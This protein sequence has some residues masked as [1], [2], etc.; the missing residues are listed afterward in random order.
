MGQLESG[1][2]KR[3]RRNQVKKIVLETI[4][5]AG[6]ISVAI[7]AP[8]V[9]G[10]MAKLGMITHPRQKEL[11]GR[12]IDR[13]YAQG[14]LKHCRGGLHL[15]QKGETHLRGLQFKSFSLNKPF[16]WDGKWR[17]LIF[18]ISER[19]RKLRD[20]VRR[21]LQ[22]NGFVRI[23]D[24]VWVYPYD[25]EDWVNLWKADRRIGKQLLYLIVDSIESDSVL[26]RKF[27]I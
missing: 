20:E 18:D 4:K 12:S 7:V 24:S 26:K 2:K 11:V 27:D 23:Q 9:I 17:V 8:N 5:A 16:R 14:L 19:E 25:C 10:A 6:I 13:M 15:T 21:T 1:S 3:A 22:G